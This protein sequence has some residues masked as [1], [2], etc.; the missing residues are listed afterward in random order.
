MMRD[1]RRGAIGR[2]ATAINSKQA[3]PLH[4]PPPRQLVDAVRTRYPVWSTLGLESVHMARQHPLTWLLKIIEDLYDSRYAHSVAELEYIAGGGD[5]PEC[6]VKELMGAHP[7]PEYVVNYCGR[8]YGVR[9]LAEKAAWEVMCNAEAARSAGLHTSVDLFCAFCNRGYDDEELMFF[10]YCR[11]TLLVECAR[12]I[13][14]ADPAVLKGPDQRF[15][16]GLPVPLLPPAIALTAKRARAVTRAVFGGGTEAEGGMLFQAVMQLV[17][18]FFS[19][20]QP[21][22]NCRGEGKGE[23]GGGVRAGVHRGQTV[24]GEE[25]REPGGTHAGVPA[26]YSQTIRGGERPRCRTRNEGGIPREAG[27]NRRKR[28]STRQGS[29]EFRGVAL[30]PVRRK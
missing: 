18:G 13:P 22:Q 29:D 19:Q 7:F 12:Y 10:L 11:Q 24:R 6:D 1:E 15:L 5:D 21:Q 8:Q 9:A 14:R 17:T 20:R 4:P 3:G 27:S 2:N 26:H 25:A 16:M 23:E 28:N 30:E